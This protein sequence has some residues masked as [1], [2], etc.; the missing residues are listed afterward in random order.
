MVIASAELLTRTLANLV[1]N[2]VKYAGDVGLNR[3]PVGKRKYEN[4][5]CFLPTIML[6]EVG[7]KFSSFM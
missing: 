7:Q 3:V 4:Q 1:G 2:A 6:F 5:Y